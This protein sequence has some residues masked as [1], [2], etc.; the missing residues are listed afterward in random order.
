MPTRRLTT[1]TEIEDFVHGL[2]LFGTG[3]GGGPATQAIDRLNS[4]LEAGAPVGWTDIDELPTDAWTFSVAGVGGRAPAGGPDPAL[5][6]RTGLTAYAYTDFL[7]TQ[8]AA[9]RALARLHDVELGAII[10]VELGSGNTVTPLLVALALGIPLVDGDYCGRAKP[11][12][13]Q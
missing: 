2:V 5:L 9:T 6:R 1:P 10:P 13:Q 12:I 8:L 3:G 4:A 11:E 7:H